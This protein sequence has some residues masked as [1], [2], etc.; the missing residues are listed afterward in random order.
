MIEKQE[1]MRVGNVVQV[2]F[3]KGTIRRLTLMDCGNIVYVER[4]YIQFID[5][6]F[7][8]PYHPK[9]VFEL[10]DEPV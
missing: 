7:D 5:Q 3:Q 10:K 4:F 9:D 1:W 6:K 8:V 2:L